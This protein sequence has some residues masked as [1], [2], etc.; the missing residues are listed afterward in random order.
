[1]AE[2]ITWWTFILAGARKLVAWGLPRLL[3]PAKLKT[4]QLEITGATSAEVLRIL[5]G[6]R[7]YEDRAP[8]GRKVE[9]SEDTQRLIDK[10]GC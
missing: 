10:N 6:L 2:N 3:T 9:K 4:E 7:Q 1:M 8:T 5:E